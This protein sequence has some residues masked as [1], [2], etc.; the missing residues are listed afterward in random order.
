MRVKCFAGGR[1]RPVEI[2][3]LPGGYGE[4][5][6]AAG[7]R[8]YLWGRHRDDIGLLRRPK[9]QDGLRRGCEDSPSSEA[10]FLGGGSQKDRPCRGVQKS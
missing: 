3:E 9:Q 5:S 6:E 10:F 1:K 4:G 8:D 2:Q 7:C